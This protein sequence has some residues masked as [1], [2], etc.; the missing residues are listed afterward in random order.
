MGRKATVPYGL[1]RAHGFVSPALAARDDR[2]RVQG[3]GFSGADLGL[4]FEALENMFEHDRSAARGLMGTR[5]LVIFEHET[6]LGDAPAHALFDKVKIEPR[7]APA[8]SFAD[9]EVRVDGELLAGV[10]AT[11]RVKRGEGG[12]TVARAGG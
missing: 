3:T 5:A 7:H 4:L 2:R 1:Y 8:R 12:F 10:R 11:Y 9:Y 6:A